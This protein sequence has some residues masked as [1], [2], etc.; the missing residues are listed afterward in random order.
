VETNP[1]ELEKTLRGPHVFK[2]NVYH[3]T[4]QSEA[5]YPKVVK[6]LTDKD[7]NATG[8]V[9]TVSSAEEEAAFSAQPDA[10]RPA[11]RMRRS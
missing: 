10:P 1:I 6:H 2:E 9:I 5:E 3:R 4:A 7:G 11:P 8:E